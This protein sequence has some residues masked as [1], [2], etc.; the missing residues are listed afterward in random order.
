MQDALA[1]GVGWMTAPI[2]NRHTRLV[3]VINPARCSLTLQGWEKVGPVTAQL[4]L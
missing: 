3:A 4:T 2:I 1:Q